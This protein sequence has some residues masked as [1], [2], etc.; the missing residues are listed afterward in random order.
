MPRFNIHTTPIEDLLIVDRQPIE[1]KR[2]CFERIFCDEELNMVLKGRHIVQI[3]QSLTMCKGIV[4]G[5]HFQYPPYSEMKLVSCLQG[6]VFDVAIDLRMGSKTFLKWH[7]EILNKTNHKTMAIPEGFAHGF[8]TLTDNCLLLYL[9]TA[10]YNK[11]AE[12]GL[13]TQDPGLGINWQI[14]VTEI[15]ERDKSHKFIDSNFKGLNL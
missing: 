14:P 8:Q 9:H 15:S 7:A 3:N 5:L 13:N 4:R 2:G 10:H 12:G 1:D 11:T 6:E